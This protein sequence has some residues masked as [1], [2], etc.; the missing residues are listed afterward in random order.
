MSQGASALYVPNSD[1]LVVMQRRTVW[2]VSAVT[3]RTGALLNTE[4]GSDFYDARTNEL[5]SLK[6]TRGSKGFFPHCIALSANGGRLALGGNDAQLVLL[7]GGSLQPLTMR[8]WHLPFD[9]AGT[10]GEVQALAF[11]PD[12][13]MLASVANDDRLVVGDAQTGDPLA[14]AKLSVEAVQ[15]YSR[16]ERRVCWSADGAQIAVTNGEGRIEIFDVSHR[17]WH[18]QAVNRR[19]RAGRL[20][21]N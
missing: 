20:G 11:S 7:D 17:E 18:S 9:D 19:S 13:Q 3:G 8:I 14:E 1:D 10:N 4:A 16:L 6:R 2:R 5:F 12:G 15:P 21:V